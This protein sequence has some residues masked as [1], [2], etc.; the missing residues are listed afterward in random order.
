MHLYLCVCACVCVHRCRERGRHRP[1][2]RWDT[3]FIHLKYCVRTSNVVQS[4]HAHAHS[5]THTRM[6]ILPQ[7]RSSAH[8]HTHTRVCVF[9]RT[10]AHTQHTHPRTHAQR[11]I[12]FFYIIVQTYDVWLHSRRHPIEFD[13]GTRPF[14]SFD[15]NIF[16]ATHTSGSNGKGVAGSAHSLPLCWKVVYLSADSAAAA[17]QPPLFH[18]SRIFSQKSLI[19]SQECSLV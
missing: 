15:A 12:V 16:D 10:N 3:I 11:E 13:A 8:R 6:N 14:A 1:R 7:K 19:L 18:K 17:R 4:L 5:Y 9:V 2:L